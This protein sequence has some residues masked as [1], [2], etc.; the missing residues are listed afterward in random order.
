MNRV[1]SRFRVGVLALLASLALAAPASAAGPPAGGV[2]LS[3]GRTFAHWAHPQ[4]RATV[5]QLPSSTSRPVGRI[6]YLTEDGFPEVYSVLRSV[7][8]P[9]G[10]TWLLI[11]IPMRP[12]ART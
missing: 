10:R 2:R 8:G 4:L 3:D 9:D 12:T 11:R 1:R 6:H 5:R 7:T